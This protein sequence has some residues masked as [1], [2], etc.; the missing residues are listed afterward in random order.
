MKRLW[1]AAVLAISMV[2]PAIARAAPCHTEGSSNAAV[3]S[4]PRNDGSDLAFARS[5]LGGFYEGP[6]AGLTVVSCER[7]RV[8]TAEGEYLLTGEND[9]AQPRRAVPA[10][11]HVGPVVY[12]T[13]PD[14]ASTRGRRYELVVSGL[15][16]I[17][18]V[19]RFYS[20]IPTDQTLLNDV[21]AV[22]ADRQAF[23][24]MTTATH[25]VRYGFDPGPTTNGIPPPI[26]GTAALP[27]GGRMSQGPQVVVGGP[28]PTE[29]LDLQAGKFR[30]KPS[31]LSCPDRFEGAAILLVQIDPSATGAVCTYK[32]GLDPAYDP[33]AELRYQLV[34]SNDPATSA[35]SAANQIKASGAASGGT[36]RAAPLLTGPAPAPTFA[37]FFQLPD[38]RV[39]GAWIAKVGPWIAL[40]RATYSASAANDA[41]AA[42]VA[43]KVFAEILGPKP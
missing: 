28:N 19:K 34:I 10:D 5:M 37:V 30:H 21:R 39:G 15:D 3:I 1:C 31:G 18:L 27:G 22:L 7:G 41:E 42:I 35:E 40:L 4:F 2:F 17:Q 11:G 26:D 36:E 8:P 25:L 33:N 13:T 16:G 23:I 20:G 24:A 32:V 43:R 12:L 14:A 6:L 38:G 29:F 9:D